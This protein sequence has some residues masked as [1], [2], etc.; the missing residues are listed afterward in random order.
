MNATSLG[1]T[2]EEAVVS[3]IRRAVG[4]GPTPLHEPYFG[5]REWEYVRACLDSSFVSSVGPF[6]DRFEIQLAEYTGAAYAV[7]VVNG[8]AAL[9]VALQLAGVRPGDEVLAPALT[10]VATA[11]AITY[12]GAVPHFIDSDDRTL[13]IDPIRLRQ[14]L[15][16]V[17]ERR[18][19]ELTN[20]AT[21]RAMRALLPMHTFGHPVDMEGVLQVAAEFGLVVV[22]DAAES[23]GSWY[24]GRH[25]GTMGRLGTLSFNGNKTITTGG[26][27]AI[28][29]DDRDLARQ[30]KHLTT[31]AK[32]P[33]AWRFI[34]DR[35]GFNYRMPN[36]N[37]ALGCAQL[38]QLPLLLDCK[39]RLFGMYREAFAGVPGVRLMEEPPG[40]SSN[41]WLHAVLLEQGGPELRDS[42]VDAANAAG[43]GTRPAWTLMHR[44]DPF[45]ACPRMDL[46]VAERLANRLISLPSSAQLVMNRPE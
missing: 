21:G 8:T 27:G 24:R 2:V 12:C 38:E 14:Y 41:Y 5:G 43:F 9:H 46:A 10:F 33:H 13:G 45:R 39:R 17:S 18:G 26:G 32:L 44:L 3:A 31:T 22:E 36:I 34:H 1:Q 19:G 25:T 20:R 4:D 42:I 37:A 16:T 23:L 7:A 28:L 35:V 15:A 6:V 40:S 30:A 11:N 29:T